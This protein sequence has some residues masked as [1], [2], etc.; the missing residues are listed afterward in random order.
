MKHSVAAALLLAVSPLAYAQEPG[1]T[2]AATPAPAKPAATPAPAAVETLATKAE[3]TPVVPAEAPSMHELVNK[4]NEADLEEAV[5][6]LKE[7]FIKPELL[8]ETELKRAMLEGIIT[9]LAPGAALM[10]AATAAAAES[11]P[12][13]SEILDDRIGY[14]RLGSTTQANL[15]EFDAALAKFAEKALKSLI[16]DLRATPAGSE[17]LQTAEVCRR[18]VPKGRVLFTV[19]KPNV[20]QEEVLTSKDDPK[21]QG[22]I[23][24]LVD[25]DTAGNAEVIAAV[26]RTHAKAMVIG[27]QTRGEAVE[28]SNYPLPGGQVLRVAVAEVSLPDKVAVFPG[29]V[30]P[31]LVVQ[32]SPETTAEVL[33]LGLEKGVAELVFE[34][35]RPRMNE[36]ALVAGTNPE[37]DAVIEAQKNKGEKPKTPVRDV[38]L[39]RALDFITTL[40]I[41]EQQKPKAAK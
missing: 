40:A 35:E 34:T 37:L 18:F 39:Q 6:V 38:V 4:L 21:Y 5:S 24:V 15:A 16:V 28:F 41:Y 22:L 19:R 23:V 10:Q 33:K 14:V 29:G 27:Q 26:L 8:N 7:H 9:R 17:F 3:E 12:F 32:V 25:K 11:S 1:K 20:N 2:P 31:D 30:T 36:A 13:R